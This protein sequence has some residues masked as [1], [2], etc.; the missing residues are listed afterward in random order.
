MTRASYVWVET[1]GI[2][3]V[4][5]EQVADAVYV[6][7]AHIVSHEQAFVVSSCL[8]DTS[9]RYRVMMMQAR[10]KQR[11]LWKEEQSAL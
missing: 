5:K 10:S 6:S 11:H 1:A 4:Y 8:D 9:V 3:S 2:W 7:D